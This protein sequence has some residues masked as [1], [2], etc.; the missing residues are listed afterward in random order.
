MKIDDVSMTYAI[1][2]DDIEFRL[3]SMTDGFDLIVTD[4]ALTKLV[5]TGTEA[6]R[7]LSTSKREH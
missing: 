7:T 3:G 5:A 6:L 4:R 2:G 1:C